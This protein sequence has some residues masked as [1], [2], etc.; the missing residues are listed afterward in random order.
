MGQHIAKYHFHCRGPRRRKVRE[1]G[2]KP[3]WRNNGLRKKAEMG[4]GVHLYGDE[5]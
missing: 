2:R 1:K 3:M 4:K 5:S